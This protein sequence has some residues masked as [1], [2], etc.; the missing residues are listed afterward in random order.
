M[1]YCARSI[2]VD[3][4]WNMLL[5]PIMVLFTSFNYLL[6]FHRCRA[7]SRKF[8]IQSGWRA[9]KFAFF[10]K[11]NKKERKICLSLYFWILNHWFLSFLSLLPSCCDFNIK[12]ICCSKHTLFSLL[13]SK[14]NIISPRQAVGLL[15]LLYLCLYGSVDKALYSSLPFFIFSVNVYTCVKG[16]IWSF[17]LRWCQRSV[18]RLT[19]CTLAGSVML[20]QEGSGRWILSC[21]DKVPA[22]ICSFINIVSSRLSVCLLHHSL[23]VC[24]CSLWILQK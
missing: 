1:L 3:P 22:K 4:C 18:L 23:A 2:N 24:E 16:N 10:F 8:V 15:L 13:L 6:C 11:K 14:G 21:S 9:F 7:V 20:E 19:P 17:S 12:A 5:F